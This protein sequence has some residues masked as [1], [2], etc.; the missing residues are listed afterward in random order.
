MFIYAIHYGVCP[1]GYC[2]FQRPFSIGKEIF[3]INYPLT[4]KER[5]KAFWPSVTTPQL[6]GRRGLY[7]WPADGDT[8]FFFEEKLR[9]EVQVVFNSPDCDF[10]IHQFTR[11]AHSK[12]KSIFWVFL[13]CSYYCWK[14]SNYLDTGSFDFNQNL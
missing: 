12:P 2:N 1:F 5:T 7:R 3:Q 14:Y 6:L 8:V 13:S 4:T 9:L 11:L 10:A